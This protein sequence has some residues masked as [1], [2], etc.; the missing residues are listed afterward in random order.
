MPGTFEIPLERMDPQTGARQ[1]WLVLKPTDPTGLIRIDNLFVSSDQ[2]TWAF[3]YVRV[4]DS[5]LFVVKGV[6]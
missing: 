5:N 1:P 4:T 2:Q 3:N 6:R